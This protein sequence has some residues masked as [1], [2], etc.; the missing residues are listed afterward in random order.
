MGFQTGREGGREG[1]RVSTF[2][3][4]LST[5]APLF[6]H[7]EVLLGLPCHIWTPICAQSAQLGF[8]L[9]HLAISRLLAGNIQE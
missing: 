6:T 1:G 9:S 4:T 2:P 7:R 8:L 5:S 3:S